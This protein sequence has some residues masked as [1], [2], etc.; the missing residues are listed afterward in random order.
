[1]YCSVSG[2]GEDGPLAAV[3]GHDLNYAAWA[4]V[5]AP[6]GGPPR[7]PA[8][9][10]ADLSGGMAAAFAVCAALFRRLRTGEGERIDVA[11]ADVLATWTG[12]APP[13]AQGVDA[14]VRGVPGYGTF[15]TADDGYV[16]LGVV[17]E[18][19][20]WS[21]LCAVLSLGDLGHLGFTERVARLDELQAS[22]AEAIA[23]RERDEVVA[24]LLAADVPVAPVLSRAEMSHLSHFRHRGAVVDDGSGGPAT[25]P[26]VRL[27]RHPA[28]RRGD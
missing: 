9:P 25:G 27:H 19:H 3:P 24:G 22:V 11:M 13:V 15:A 4:G 5:L 1:V 16:A 8:I 28:Q 26:P 18:D 6:D 23:G 12:T 7:E 10:V 20:F 14:A 2:L 17:S 21:R